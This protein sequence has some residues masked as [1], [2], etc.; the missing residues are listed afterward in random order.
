MAG[1]LARAFDHGEFL[2]FVANLNLVSGA[3]LEGW[4]VHAMA[5]HVDVPVADDLPRLAPRRGE[6]QAV[7]HVVQTPLQLLQEQ[8]AGHTGLTRGFFGIITE[9]VVWHELDAVGLLLVAVLKDMT[10]DV[11]C[12]VFSMLA[13]RVVKRSLQSLK[14]QPA[15]HLE[16]TRGFF[17]VRNGKVRKGKEV[18]YG[19]QLREK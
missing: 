9:L 6:S 5:V 4:D 15:G 16:H 2:G 11:R 13:G 18:G 3:D 14:G 1:K 7:D 19:L 10:R 12:G 17:E 8:L